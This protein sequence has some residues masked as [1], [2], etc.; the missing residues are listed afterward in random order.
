MLV[1]FVFCTVLLKNRDALPP[2]QTPQVP[3]LL[4]YLQREQLEQALQGALP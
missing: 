4:Q 3:P 2:P 1:L